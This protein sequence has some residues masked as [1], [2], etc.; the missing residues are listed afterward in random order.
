MLLLLIDSLLDVLNFVGWSQQRVAILREVMSMPVLMAT[1]EQTLEEVEG[2]FEVV[3]GLPVVDSAR[4]CVG[5]V[6]KSDWTRASHG[7]SSHSSLFIFFTHN[8]CCLA[9]K[10]KKI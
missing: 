1:V 8:S 10:R 6:V 9:D 4:R 3:S 2:H 7:V 5:V